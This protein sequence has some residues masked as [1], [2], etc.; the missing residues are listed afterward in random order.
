MIIKAL[1]KEL[2][3]DNATVEMQ[4]GNHLTVA[5]KIGDEYQV[6]S[7]SCQGSVMVITH[8]QSESAFLINR[9]GCQHLKG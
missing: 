4:S 9:T 6:V 1:D 5:F 2:R 8:E 3:H 7:V